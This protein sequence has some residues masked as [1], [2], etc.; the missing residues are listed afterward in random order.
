[1]VSVLPIMLQNDTLKKLMLTDSHGQHKDRRND[2]RREKSTTKF[3]KVNL[4][5]QAVD[6]DVENEEADYTSMY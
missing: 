5:S 4:K 2:D 6:T 3:P 1:M